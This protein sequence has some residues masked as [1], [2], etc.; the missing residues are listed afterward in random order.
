MA[1]NLNIERDIS[2]FI[3]ILFMKNLLILLIC[4]ASAGS[5]FAEGKII[6]TTELDEKNSPKDRLT[7]IPF[8]KDK[9]YVMFVYDDANIAFGA[10]KVF[11][12][13]NIYDDKTS[14]YEYAALYTVDVK[15]DW[16]YC[17]K[18]ILFNA[19]MKTKIRVFSDKADIATKYIDVVN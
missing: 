5:L 3:Q 19:V 6:I 15:P 2:I 13:I 18:G 4:L 9:E 8:V 16:G 10:E 11:F 17:Y 7:E 1:R 12:E 14:K